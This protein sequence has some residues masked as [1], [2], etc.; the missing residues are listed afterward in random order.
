[1]AAVEVL[2][3]WSTQG[4]DLTKKG[5]VTVTNGPPE[6][7][8]ACLEEYREP[9][10]FLVETSASPFQEE[11]SSFVDPIITAII[12]D[13]KAPLPKVSKS[14]LYGPFIYDNRRC[15]SCQTTA[16]EVGHPLLR[17][18]GG[19]GGLEHYCTKAHQKDDWKDHKYFCCK[20][21]GNRAQS[22]MII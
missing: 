8:R 7:V 22:S 15:A 21:N 9:I 17:C 3:W 13:K 19:C 12:D 11:L 16:P 10:C 6:T 4:V 14:L 2:G 18:G 20:I 5:R 1:M